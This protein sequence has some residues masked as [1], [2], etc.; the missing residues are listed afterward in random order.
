MKLKEGMIKSLIWVTA[1]LLVLVGTSVA[2][3]GKVYAAPAPAP[4]IGVVD[5]T[6]LV[7]H[8]AVKANEALKLEQ[9]IAKREY[10]DKSG[11]LNDKG[12]QDLERQLNQRVEQKR[13]ELLQPILNDIN[14]AI[15]KVAKNKRLTVVF[16]KNYVAYGGVDIT[17]EVLKEL[18]K[19]GRK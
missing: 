5:Y 2:H 18:D 15:Q 11:I 16:Y 10:T 3:P 7:D 6:N 17:K 1:A 12:K 19:L 4:S 8:H 9:E 13:L 14:A